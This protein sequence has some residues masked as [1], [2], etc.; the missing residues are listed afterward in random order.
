MA[1]RDTRSARQAA[2]QLGGL[3]VPV[4]YGSHGIGVMYDH[5]SALVHGM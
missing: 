2:L 1:E 5:V 4:E 3:S